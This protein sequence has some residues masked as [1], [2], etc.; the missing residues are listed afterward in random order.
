MNFFLCKKC[1]KF[2]EEKS[3]NI[4]NFTENYKYNDVIYYTNAFYDTYV[5]SKNINCFNFND[6]QNIVVNNPKVNIEEEKEDELEIIDYPYEYNQESINNCSKS[7]IKKY[8]LFDEDINM[9]T[10]NT[11]ETKKTS[12]KDLFLN[13]SRKKNNKERKKVLLYQDN[14]KNKNKNN[15]INNDFKTYFIKNKKPKKYLTVNTGMKISKTFK[16]SC[17]TQPVFKNL[18]HIGKLNIGNNNKKNLKDYKG[19]N[20]SLKILKSNHSFQSRIPKIKINESYNSFKANIFPKKIGKIN[21]RNNI[22]KNKSI[23]GYNNKKRDYTMIINEAIN[24]NL[25]T[26]NLTIK[27]RS[28]LNR[29][30][31]YSSCCKRKIRKRNKRVKKD[32]TK[33]TDETKKSTKFNY[34]IS[35]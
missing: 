23:F 5:N 21:S 17:N 15:N 12:I 35:Y 3:V 11:N 28:N 26:M 27:D 33:E 10:I 32:E 24:K 14:F 7:T 16:K 8:N 22:Q 13:M 4:N 25:K 2:N 1:E 29:Y 18:K 20:N 30:I 6:K 9:M 19:D 31:I 34:T